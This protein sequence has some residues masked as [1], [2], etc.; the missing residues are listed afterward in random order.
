MVEVIDEMEYLRR[1]AGYY[2]SLR[3]RLNESM[4][5]SSK[6]AEMTSGAKDNL[7]K[8]MKAA[9]VES[10]ELNGHTYTIP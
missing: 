4:H 10:V 7:T 1:L 8:A 2:E 9:G 5:M 6:L 3:S